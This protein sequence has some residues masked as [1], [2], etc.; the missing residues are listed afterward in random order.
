MASSDYMP[1]EYPTFKDH[2]KVLDW[3]GRDI[4]NAVYTVTLGELVDKG[5]F[6]WDLDILDW[7]AQAYDEEQHAR[8]CAYFLERFRFRE[9]SIEP[10]Y[11]WA[12]LLCS[13][14]KYEL[15]PKYKSLY[16][17]YEEGFDPAIKSDKY[18]KAR[19]VGSEYPETLL[20][21][22]ADY[23][24]TGKDEEGEE[25][26]RGDLLEAYNDFV[27]GFRS[28]DQNLLDELESFFI[29]LYTANMNGM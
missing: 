23:A 15:M 24:S 26:E 20:S 27:E 10:F 9:I 12:T 13:K 28:I 5:V 19:S 16:K 11:E 29:G 25:L 21:A 6:S 1:E 8:V 18:R 3:T 2:D 22:N 14:L 4:Y 7:K 17:N